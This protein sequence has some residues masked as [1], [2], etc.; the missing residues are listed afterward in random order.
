MFAARRPFFVRLIGRLGGFDSVGFGRFNPAV[1]RPLVKLSMGPSFDR[2]VRYDRFNALP[3]RFKS[4]GCYSVGSVTDR[5]FLR[6]VGRSVDRFSFVGY[7][8]G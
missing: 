6:S 3:D 4:V 2:S 8:V 7:L 1:S 5:S